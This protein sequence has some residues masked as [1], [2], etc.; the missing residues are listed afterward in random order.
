M[1]AFLKPQQDFLPLM[2]FYIIDS[3]FNMLFK[4]FPIV[5]LQLR[6]TTLSP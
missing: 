6:F 1:G 3:S 4:L 5:A 2:I